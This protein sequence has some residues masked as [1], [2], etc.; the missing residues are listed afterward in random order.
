[1]CVMYVY[2]CE[3]NVC[4]L[5]VYSVRVYSPCNVCVYIVYAYIMCAPHVNNVV[6]VLCIMQVCVMYT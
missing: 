5:C 3:C 6:C 1:M 2:M 4:L